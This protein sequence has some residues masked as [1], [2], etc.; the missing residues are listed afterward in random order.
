MRSPP[1]PACRSADVRRAAMVAGGLGE[2][3]RASRWPKA[4]P[5]S[6]ASPSRCTGRCSRCWRSRPTTSPTRWPQLGTAALEWKLDG[7][8]VQVHKAGGEV[9]VYTRALNDVTASVPEIVE[10]LQRAA[11]RTS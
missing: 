2:V 8:R 3:A 4:R 1:P 10:A 11:G 9:R 6:R 7:A 5:A